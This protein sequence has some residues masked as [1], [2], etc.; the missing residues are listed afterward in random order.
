MDF[1]LF[2]ACHRFDESSSTANVY[3]QALEMVEFADQAGFRIAWFPEHHL[4]HYI[5]CPS[6]LMMAIKAAG[7]T[8]RIRLG[9][10]ILVIPY[11]NPLRLAGELGMA[12]ILT[13][14]RLEIGVGRGAFEYEFAK[15]GID[16]RIAAARLPD[17][18]AV[19]TRALAPGGV[20]H[21]GEGRSRR[22]RP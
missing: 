22:P 18:M 9:T 7:R 14:G 3:E 20:P 11:Y 1:G 10:A 15:F 13:G 21:R 5:S 8:T 12:D 6:P 2:V 19:G 16:E 17:G 4:I